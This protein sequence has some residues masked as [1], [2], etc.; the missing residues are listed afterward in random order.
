MTDRGLLGS[1]EQRADRTR[2]GRQASPV[3]GQ[4]WWGQGVG[5][6][7]SG[8]FRLREAVRPARP[9]GRGCRAQP[10]SSWGR[11]RVPGP[12]WLGEHL[13]TGGPAWRAA[14]QV[15][16]QSQPGRSWWGRAPGQWRHEGGAAGGSAPGDPPVAGPNARGSRESRVLTH[17]DPTHFLSGLS[18]CILQARPLGTPEVGP[19]SSPATVWRP[20]G[21]GCPV[22]SGSG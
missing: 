6:R 2:E 4:G 9:G 15:L 10:G 14:G 20:Q 1:P 5:R 22:F 12:S 19:P 17:T 7:C 21:V 3:P 13:A 8:D 11:K 18:A 16:R